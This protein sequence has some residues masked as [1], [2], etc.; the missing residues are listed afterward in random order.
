MIR[1]YEV[2]TVK[3]TGQMGRL[4][5]QMRELL[6]SINP[7]AQ[8]M[9]VS[10]SR[11]TQSS[12]FGTNQENGV[13]LERLAYSFASSRRCRIKSSSFRL[14]WYM[15]SVFA[16]SVGLL[17]LILPASLE[18]EEPA[19]RFLEALRTNHYYDVAIDYLDQ[20]Q[21]SPLVTDQFKARIPLEKADTLMASLSRIRDPRLREETLDQA[22]QVLEAFL[23]TNPS[24]ELKSMAERTRANLLVSRAGII[25]NNTRNSRLTAQQ[26]A[27]MREQARNFLLAASESFENNRTELR[28][29]IEK[30]GEP[31][32]LEGQEQLRNLRRE[33]VIVRH[34]SPSIKEKIADTYDEGSAEQR[35]LLAEAAAEFE[36]IF[37]DYSNMAGGLDSAL[38]AARC[39]SKLALHDNSL[40]LI[41]VNIFSQEN[42][43]AYY[44]YKRRGAAIAL[45]CW[46]AK[47]PLP[48]NEIIHYL[49]PIVQN[50]KPDE[51]KQADWLRLQLGFAKACMIKSEAIRD[52]RPRS[53]EERRDMNDLKST[54]IELA[55]FVSKVNSPYRNDARELLVS[56]DTRVGEVAEVKEPPTDVSEARDR[57]RDL[58]SEIEDTNNQVKYLEEQ[59][60]TGDVDP[61]TAANEL[62]QLK[63]GL[64]E[65]LVQTL[66]MIELALDLVDATTPTDDISYL[67]YLQTYCYFSM[68]QHLETTVIGRFLMDRYPDKPGA[69]EAMGL[70]C[71]SFWQMYINAASDEQDFEREQLTLNCSDLIG[72]W[73]GTIESESAAQMLTMVYLQTGDVDQAEHFIKLVPASSPNRASLLLSVG[74]AVW[75]EYVRRQKQGDATSEIQEIRERAKQHL[76]DGSATLELTSLTPFQSRC[77]LSLAELYLDEGDIEQAIHRLENA[78]IAPLD[79]VKQKH[80]ST[81]G[82]NFRMD[83]YRA[84]IRAYLGA[85]QSGENTQVWIEKAQNIIDALAR[86]FDTVE[87][88]PKRLVSVYYRLA[89]ELKTQFD[90]IEDNAQ[91]QAFGKGLDVFLSGIADNAKDTQ[92]LIWCASTMS[93]V[94]EALFEAESQELGRPMFEKAI[95]VFDRVGN[96]G[97]IDEATA[98]IMLRRKALAYRGMGRYEQAIDAF[99]QLFNDPK[100]IQFI[101]LQIDAALTF[102][103][104]GIEKK[105]EQALLQ[106]VSGGITVR[107]P[108]TS[109]ERKAAIGWKQI[110]TITQRNRDKG[111][112]QRQLYYQAILN[113]AKCKYEYAKLTSNRDVMKSAFE[114]IENFQQ[115]EP[116]VDSTWKSKFDGLIAKIKSELN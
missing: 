91:K 86:E 1:R 29:A 89:S 75:Q 30:L 92:V 99:A 77:L 84:A 102:Q 34:L 112:S 71:K 85:L 5:T 81:E 7:T 13:S 51:R 25:V 64:A 46:E 59:I 115:R 69:R 95:A 44:E 73:P 66:Q 93:S 54:A 114:E 20:M 52:D 76:L 107:D 60:Q 98:R 8:G 105:N 68:E 96:S 23:A 24:T 53:A 28:T 67:R 9:Y 35:K 65:Q 101:D 42:L 113:F 40:N 87:D 83:T 19:D 78:N 49:A 104:W 110:A 18:A 4:S 2:E 61:A 63:A 74:Q 109:R 3:T 50:I 12:R 79:L 111:E 6:S 88:G 55:R 90:S 97:G 103:E 17:L 62:E 27:A 26:V 70:V 21:T 82:G 37:H 36:K 72:R 43:P 39:Y 10:L 106:A 31:T 47:D 57:A 116:N 100:N 22:Q 41:T 33:Y 58:I 15:R 48:F 94:G 80:P 14:W 38:F 45:T 56:W 32:E 11:L 108:T 16:M